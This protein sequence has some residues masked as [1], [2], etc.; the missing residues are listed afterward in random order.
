MIFHTPN[1][2]GPSKPRSKAFREFRNFLTTVSAFSHRRPPPNQEHRRRPHVSSSVV[3]IRFSHRN[4]MNAGFRGIRD[5]RVSGHNGDQALGLGGLA[6]ETGSVAAEGGTVRRSGTMGSVRKR[7]KKGVLRRSKLLP[8]TGHVCGVDFICTKGPSGA[9]LFE[10]RLLY[11]PFMS[12][13][14][15]L[16][17][18]L[19]TYAFPIPTITVGLGKD[20]WKLHHSMLNINCKPVLNATPHW[21][22]C[23]ATVHP[24]S[25][26]SPCRDNNML[27]SIFRIRLDAS[28][29]YS[30]KMPDVCTRMSK[31]LG[32]RYR[33]LLVFQFGGLFPHQACSS[34]KHRGRSWAFEVDPC[35]TLS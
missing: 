4:T 9:K 5:L 30:N 1:A 10:I 28:R 13:I 19:Y 24:M 26:L 29:G 20:K 22:C 17:Q 31:H 33:L 25:P 34:G 6:T 16:H 18:E 14:Q 12:G 2:S 23:G 21:A 15:L 32:Q 7:N 35:K 3:S 8:S 11:Q 27:A